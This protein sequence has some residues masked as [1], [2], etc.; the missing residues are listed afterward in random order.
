MLQKTIWRNKNF[1]LL[2]FGGLVSNTGNSLHNLAMGW[3]IYELTGSTLAMSVSIISS[4]L[5]YA[6]FSVYAGVFSDNYD[7]KK[8]IIICD[9][10][11]GLGIL[12]MFGFARYGI[13]PITTILIFNVILSVISAFFNPA[14]SAA[15][16][17]VLAKDEY[18]DANT[19]S[20]LLFR[21]SRVIGAA[22][23]GFLLRIMGI[24]YLL[25]FNAISYFLSAFSEVFITLPE[26]DA[27]AQTKENSFKQNLSTAINFVKQ[28]K[29][30]LLLAIYT[31]TILEG[32]AVSIQ[33]FLPGI[34]QDM[35]KTSIELG[36]YRA[37]TA[38]AATLTSIYLLNLKRNLDPY[39][40]ILIALTF[41]GVQI[42]GLGLMKSVLITYF[43]G[44]LA[45]FSFCMC[46]TMTGVLNQMLIPNEIMGR[47]SSF[48]ELLFTASMPISTI[49]F[50]IVGEFYNYQII[51]LI[52]GM[53]FLIAMIPTPFIFA[54]EKSLSI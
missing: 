17:A 49:F 51:L 45:G 43:L 16:H 37:I 38:I 47:I 15:Y 54:K 23:G 5:P 41:Q 7:R 39:K 12:A 18:Q 11:S 25:L 10:L 14:M 8:I 50:G 2:W 40:W 13:L 53:L 33:I 24:E 35:G 36:L 27:I 19:L 30:I 20:Q 22:M 3:F 29:I 26:K 48:Y 52:S 1:L 21:I 46:G 34:L 42:L 4:Y 32:F 31:I 9:T 28:N 6:I 44:A